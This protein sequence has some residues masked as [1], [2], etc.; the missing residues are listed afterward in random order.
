MYTTP[1]NL[2]RNQRQMCSKSSLKRER[3]IHCRSIQQLIGPCR[4]GFVSTWG[5]TV[6]TTRLTRTAV[7]ISCSHFSPSPPCCRPFS[8]TG[9]LLD[10]YLQLQELQ[11]ILEPSWRLF[12]DNRAGEHFSDPPPLAHIFFA[13]LYQHYHIHSSK[14][15]HKI[16]IHNVCSY[17][18][19]LHTSLTT[20]TLVF[21]NGASST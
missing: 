11:L 13:S 17:N 2:S 4:V 21:A 8:P 19:S 9:M 15:A 3:N 1:S 12:V 6:Q 14:H 7:K 10:C 5:R 18:Y 16:I 20:D